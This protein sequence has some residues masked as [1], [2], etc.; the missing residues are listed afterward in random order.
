MPIGKALNDNVIR[1]SGRLPEIWADRATTDAKRKALLRC[2][3]D[4][5]ILDRGE[6]DVG[7]VRIVWRGGAVSETRSENARQL[8]S[9]AHARSR[10]AGACAGARSR[11]NARR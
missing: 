10:N 6:H 11:Q 5:V 8:G 2:L 4:K 9:E 1:L 3:V 7:L